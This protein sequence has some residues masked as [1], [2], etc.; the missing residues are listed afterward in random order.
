MHCRWVWLAGLP[1]VITHSSGC[2]TMPMLPACSHSRGSRKLEAA[3]RAARVERHQRRHIAQLRGGDAAERPPGGANVGVPVAT[4]QITGMHH[5]QRRGQ[6]LPSCSHQ[7]AVGVS[8]HAGSAAHGLAATHMQHVSWFSW[9]RDGAQGGRQCFC[10]HQRHQPGICG[11]V[12]RKP[13]AQQ[14]A[15][16]LCAPQH[17]SIF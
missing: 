13:A 16:A 14:Q 4:N 8:G 15:S 17:L 12:M 3:H 7:C 11:R 10:T 2:V 1:F 6:T 5:A 9:T